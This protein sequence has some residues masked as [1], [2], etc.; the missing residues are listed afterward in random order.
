MT[1][2]SDE[3]NVCAPSTTWAWRKVKIA[4]PPEG[5]TQQRRSRYGFLRLTRQPRSRPVR[6]TLTY[7]GGPESRWLVE[8]RGTR[9]SFIGSVYL[10]DVMA[11]V[12]SER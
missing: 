8:A 2:D 11:R 9:E 4:R 7:R 12:L 1:S 3:S 6:L 5:T 10:E